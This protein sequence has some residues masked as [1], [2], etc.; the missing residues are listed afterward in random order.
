[1]ATSPNLPHTLDERR[2]Q[3]DEADEITPTSKQTKD[4]SSHFFSL[5]PKLRD[6]INSYILNHQDCYSFRFPRCTLIA[7]DKEFERRPPLTF[8]SD[9]G[10][11]SAWSFA[12]M[13]MLIEAIDTLTREKAFHIRQFDVQSG[14]AKRP[15]PI[16][17]VERYENHILAKS[18][19]II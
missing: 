10:R 3:A 19:R 7:Y 17:N 11:C 16:G 4:T 13:Q 1:M 9:Y 6:Q 14:P 15:T 8:K 5:S 18:I 2:H 12:N